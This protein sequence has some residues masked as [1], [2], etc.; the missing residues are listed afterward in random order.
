MTKTEA[1][2]LA[3][4]CRAALRRAGPKYAAAGAAGGPVHAALAGYPPYARNS[5]STLVFP[6]TSGVMEVVI[7]NISM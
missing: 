4:A 3:K 7:I 1:R 5:G 2:K 6:T